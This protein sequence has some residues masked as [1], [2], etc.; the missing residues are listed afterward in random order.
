[1]ASGVPATRKFDVGSIEETGNQYQAL[2]GLMEY[3]VPALNA[4][5]RYGLPALGAVGIANA[6][7]G[8]YDIAE[9]TPV[10]PVGN[11]QSYD[12]LSM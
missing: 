11:Q 8:L 2:R 3:G 9:Q 4:G 5:T 10:F 7:G 1:M 6:V 12:T